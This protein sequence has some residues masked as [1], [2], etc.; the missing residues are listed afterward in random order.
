MTLTKKETE[1]TLVNK[2]FTLV[3]IEMLHQILHSYCGHYID[4]VTSWVTVMCGIKNVPFQYFTNSAPYVRNQQT[5]LFSILQIPYLLRG[6]KNV[7]FQY[8]ANSVPVPHQSYIW[9]VT[10][11]TKQY[12]KYV[13]SVLIFFKTYLTYVN[14]VCYFL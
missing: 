11:F 6:I 8:F 2:I 13:N 5:Y 10:S 4:R 9:I 7:P 1:V 14:Y 12:K 3:K